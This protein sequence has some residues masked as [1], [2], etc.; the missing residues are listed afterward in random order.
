MLASIPHIFRVCQEKSCIS[1]VGRLR[2]DWRSLLLRDLNVK[3]TINLITFSMYDILR[4][5]TRNSQIFV[6]SNLGF[7]SQNQNRLPFFAT[8]FGIL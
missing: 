5:I 2:K 3:K 4:N 8:I 7:L 1:L 6:L